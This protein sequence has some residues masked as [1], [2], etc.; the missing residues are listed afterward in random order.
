MQIGFGLV[1]I[2]EN[3]EAQK[4]S[5]EQILTENLKIL[6]DNNVDTIVLVVRITHF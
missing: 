4:F 1:N 2:V 3:G 6:I 5:T